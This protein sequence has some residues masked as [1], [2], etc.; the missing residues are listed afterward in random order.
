MPYTA[1]EVMAMRDTAVRAIHQG[2]G[3]EEL[4]TEAMLLY[5]QC[6]TPKPSWEQ[7]G[8]TTRSVWIERVL[9]G[10]RADLS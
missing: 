3:P 9:A 4:D 6:L 2:L 10:E 1:A 8:E 5:E 7:L